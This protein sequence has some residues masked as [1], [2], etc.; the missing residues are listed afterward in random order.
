M[1]GVEFLC[2]VAASSHA[3]AG[4]QCRADSDCQ[5]YMSLLASAGQPARLQEL[6]PNGSPADVYFERYTPYP[7]WRDEEMHA[8]LVDAALRI[9]GTIATSG[10][11]IRTGQHVMLRVD[12]I[13]TSNL[14]VLPPYL[15]CHSHVA[16]VFPNCCVPLRCWRLEHMIS[17]WCLG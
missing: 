7:I 2:F 17:L 11:P 5:H 10:R 13:K 4:S 1:G 6:Y 9:A 12:L 3:Y 15:R 8:L 14:K 16:S